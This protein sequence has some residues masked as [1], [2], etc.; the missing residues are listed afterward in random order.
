MRPTTRFSVQLLFAVVL[1]FMTT[2]AY[3]QQRN[4]QGRKMGQNQQNFTTFDVDGNGLITKKEFEQVKAKRR[5]NKSGKRRNATGAPSFKS[6]DVDG[7]GFITKAE[8]R[9]KRATQNKKRQA[10]SHSK[11][12]SN[13]KKS[14]KGKN[15][16]V[17][18]R[19]L[20]VDGNG[21]ITPD[22]LTQAQRVRENNRKG[23]KAIQD[24]PFKRIDA[25]GDG[26]ITRKE[27]ADFQAKRKRS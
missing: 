25:N 1:V 4:G 14:K 5:S 20:D 8:F 2:T 7:D 12:K 16:Q 10:N 21:L 19:T 6:F 17:S 23:A 27:Y 26:E 3:T 9:Q 11:R 22:E 15:R 18:F 24:V 13:R